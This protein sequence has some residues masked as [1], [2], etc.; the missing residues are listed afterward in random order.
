MILHYYLAVWYNNLTNNPIT[1]YKLFGI[2]M[3]NF[4]FYRLSIAIILFAVFFSNHL[5]AEKVILL[6]NESTSIKVIENTYNHLIIQ[7][8]VADFEYFAKETPNGMFTELFVSGYGKPEKLG[9]PKLPVLRKLIEIPL[10]AAVQINIISYETKDYSLRE[11]GLQYPVYPDQ[12]PSLISDP[13]EFV[14]NNSFYT[15]NEFLFEELVKVEEMGIMR[16]LRLANLCISPV[17]Y[18]PVTQTL[19]FYQ[20]LQ[21][22]VFFNN[23]DIQATNDLKARTNSFYFDGSFNQFLNYKPVQTRDYITK[24][25]VKYVIVSDP[26]FEEALQ[27]FIEWKQRKGF[28]VIEA[29]T[30]NPAVGSITTSIKAYLQGLYNAGTSLDPAPSFV[31]FVGDVA[32]IPSWESGLHVTDLRYCEYTGDN[33]PEVYYGRFSANNVSELL[34]QINK[35]LMY[36]QYLF[37]DP[38]YLNEVVRIAGM[39]ETMAEVCFN[40][41][42][43]YGTA[44]YFNAANGLLSHTYIYPNSG[45]QSASIIQDINNGAGFVSY[46]AHGTPE[47]W[48]APSFTNAD[49]TNLQNLNKYPTIIGQCCLSN[50]FDEPSCFGETLLRADDKGAVAY[51]GISDLGYT[52]EEFY[53]AVGVGTITANPTYAGTTLG[54]LDRMFH[55]NG[56]AFAEWY[57]TQSQMIFGGNIAV[58]EGMPSSSQ[59]Y[60]EVYHVMGDPSLVS[61]FSEAPVSNTSYLPV[62]PFGTTELAINTEPYGYAAISKDGILY[63]AALADSNGLAQ[64]DLMNLIEPGEAEIVVTNQ[65]VQ[66]FFGTITI[67]P[68]EEAYISYSNHT[69]SDRLGNQI[70]Q[71]INGESILLSLALK[72]I[73]L[74][75]ANSVNV[76]ISSDSPYITITDSTEFYGTMNPNVLLSISNGFTFNISNITPC[77]HKAEFKKTATFNDSTTSESYFSVNISAPKLEVTS[78]TILDQYGNNNGKLDPGETVQISIG[79]KNNG[80]TAAMNVSSVLECNNNFINIQQ[81]EM[82][83]GNI[84]IN[85]EVTQLFTITIDNNTP[86]ATEVQFGNKV[87]LDG[88]SVTTEYKNFDIGQITALI[89]NKDAYSNS[90][91]NLQLA[92]QSIEVD[93]EITTEFPT[94]FNKYKS[95]FVLLGSSSQSYTLSAEDGN[96][97]ASYLD[98]GGNL[99]ME[100]GATWFTLLQR[101]VH[102]YFN[103][104]AVNSPYINMGLIGQPG[105]F[106]EG[107]T[108]SYSGSSLINGSIEAISPAFVIF[109]NVFGNNPCVVAHNAANYKTIAS[110]FLFGGFNNGNP[111]ST[112]SE[113]LNRYL[114]FFDV[115]PKDYLTIELPD[116]WKMIS[117][118]VSPNELSVE[119]IMSEVEDNIRIMK[120]SDGNHY[121]PAFNINTIGNWDIKQGYY[122][123]MTETSLLHI[124]GKYANPVNTPIE[125]VPGW[126][127]IAYLRNSQMDAQTALASITSD[128][129]LVK[130]DE[131][132]YV[133]AYGI[134][135]IGDMEPGKGYYIYVLNNTSLTYPANSSR[136]ENI[137]QISCND[138]HINLGTGNSMVL[139]LKA[140]NLDEGTEILAKSDENTIYGNGFVRNGLAALLVWGDDELKDCK[141]GFQ[142]NEAINLFANN[143]LI[144]ISSTNDLIQQTSND[145][146]SYKTDALAYAEILESQVSSN[147]IICYP[148]PA[149]ENV[150]ISYYLENECNVS[151]DI[152]SATGGLI[153]RINMGI[154]EFGKHNYLLDL[155]DFSSGVFSIL[156]NCGGLIKTERILVVK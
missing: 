97:L 58:T 128:F 143:K 121:I 77:Y 18:N 125:L 100:G 118:N 51:I 95:V 144:N 120:D 48:Y 147:E 71:A 102:Q 75:T 19:R 50:K 149:K 41:V 117:S 21:V 132:M 148:Q 34:P 39:D 90:A 83:Y 153:K 94:N 27:P 84:A 59:Y 109:R 155:N 62:L 134:N 38:S 61:F 54:A 116:S 16:S 88:D 140:E 93:Y 35:T 80:N 70:E 47:G 24:Y 68:P 145:Y 10:G 3:K 25:P 5:K 137:E 86:L 124:E 82:I 11:L 53:W 99:Y 156:L 15:R 74:D 55:S 13:P 6:E 141:N 12:P 36:E 30:N 52:T 110:V 4:T 17:R 129:L 142:N 37:P 64:I 79:M 29:Y 26:M 73:G 23:P 92:F 107:M 111:P 105:T 104:N 49:V 40:G 113:L 60:W 65:N 119:S 1:K 122:V 138:K 130:N 76:K 7:N 67:T 32:Q 9:A 72:N 123:N 98:S 44:Y 66:P 20:N 14:Y 115:F 56:E 78:F 31:L 127:I 135:T 87:L 101:A 45:S 91:A 112:R 43:N 151:I 63:G 103:I 126:H 22:E 150:N 89:I 114:H 57:V 33:L 85:E 8:T 96:L 152:L 136:K 154:Q 108:F 139:I 2:V 28:K 146:I 46:F 106:T 81:N 131:G 133:P 42:V 69:I